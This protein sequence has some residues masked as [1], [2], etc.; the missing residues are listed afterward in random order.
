MRKIYT[1]KTMD[2]ILPDGRIIKRKVFSYQN[3]LVA[4]VTVKGIE[5]SIE[6]FNESSDPN[7]I[8]ILGCTGIRELKDKGAQVIVNEKKP[9]GDD[10]H[11]IAHVN[12]G[13]AYPHLLDW[14][15]CATY[16]IIDE[17]FFDNVRK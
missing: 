4:F 1:E 11:Y 3:I 17:N 7:E 12:Y 2:I 16:A 5:F 10:K 13:K 6:K 9:W 14:T 15:T 8:A